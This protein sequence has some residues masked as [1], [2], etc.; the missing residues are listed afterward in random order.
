MKLANRSD[1]KGNSM[2]N[3]AEIRRL[4]ISDEIWERTS[5][6]W[7]E[8]KPF[9]NFNVF[10]ESDESEEEC[11]KRLKAKYNIPLEVITQWIYPHYYNDNTVKNYG[12]IDYSNVKFKKNQL[13][14][15]QLSELYVVRE[16]LSYVRIRQCSQPFDEFMCTPIDKQHWENNHTWRVPPVILDVKSFKK[17]PIYA[18]II[19]PYQL[20]E[21]HSRL[22]YLL[23][24][25]QAG[26]LRKNNHQIYL[27]S[28]NSQDLI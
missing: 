17:I 6:S 25:Q 7:K 24:M 5:T 3:E 20:I 13:T 16:Y 15:K 18:E 9:R 28:C 26:I 21:G 8:L 10:D 12:W 19:G 4:Y 1:I 27:L 2:M 11:F 14:I 23:A 22:G